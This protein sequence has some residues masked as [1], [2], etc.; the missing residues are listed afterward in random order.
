MSGRG[1][2]RAQH[3]VTLPFV[4]GFSSLARG[5]FDCSTDL[6]LRR[7]VVDRIGAYSQHW[8]LMRAASRALASQPPPTRRLTPTP[9]AL[10]GTPLVELP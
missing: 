9:R 4:S 8:M 7:P 5:S 10:A 3:D 1:A 2:T 6:P